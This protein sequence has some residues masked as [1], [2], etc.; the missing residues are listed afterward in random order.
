MSRVEKIIQEIEYCVQKKIF[1]KLEDDKLDLKDNSHSSSDWK[2]VF[3]TA[4]A[5][6]NTSGGIIIIGIHE[7]EKGQNFT[8]KGFNKANEEKLKTIK[9]VFTNGKREKIDL[10]SYF[11]FHFYEILG[12]Q[13][14][15]VYIDELPEDIKFV[16]FEGVAYE[17]K[18]T[19][20][21][22]IPENKITAQ[23]EYKL[24]IQNDK[25]LQSVI[26]AKI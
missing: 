11:T 19:G 26:N 12:T 7:D 8:I 1:K 16:Y 13:I 5:F 21:H 10:E 6:L 4:C 9:E 14:L 3:K 20:D 17:R 22:K 23:E 15:A 18:M 2:E 25:E 24:E